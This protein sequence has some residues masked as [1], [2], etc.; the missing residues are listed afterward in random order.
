MFKMNQILLGTKD[1][2]Y[3]KTCLCDFTKATLLKRNLHGFFCTNQTIYIK[4][5]FVHT[6]YYYASQVINLLINWLKTR[7]SFYSF[8]LWWN[9]QSHNVFWSHVMFFIGFLLNSLL[10]NKIIIIFC[11]LFY[12]KGICITWGPKSNPK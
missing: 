8:F 11:S 12:N 7:I 5:F 4:E 6:I 2:I 1:F 3:T 10:V 9:I